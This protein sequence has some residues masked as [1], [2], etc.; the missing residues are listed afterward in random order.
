MTIE[1]SVLGSF[2]AGGEG[3]AEIVAHDPITQ[4]LFVIDGASAEIDVLDVSDPTNPTPVAGVSPI[5]NPAFNTGGV[6]PDSL[7]NSIDVRDGL[8]AVA[9]AANPETDPGTVFFYDTDGNLIDSVTVG[10]L[11]DML[12][13][14]PDGTKILVAN[15]GE[16]DGTDP[17]GS[18]SIIDIS[19]GVDGVTPPPVTQ[20]EFTGFNGREQELRNDGVRIFEGNTAAQDFEPEYIAVSPDGTT[21][22]V[23]L[24]ENNAVAVLDIAS[25]TITDVLPLGVKDYSSGQPVLEQIDLTSALPDLGVTDGGQTIKLG[26]L[27]GLH[28]GGMDGDNMVFFTVPDRGPNAEPTNVDGDPNEERPLALPDYQA[29]I[30]EF[31]VAPDGTV[32]FPDPLFLTRDDDGTSVPITGRP[33][34]VGD[35]EPVDLNGNPLA[36]DPFGGDFEGIVRASDGSFWMVDEYRPAIYHFGADGVLI[37][38]FVPEG[39]GVLGGGSAGDFGTE[40]LPEEYAERR[41]NRGFEAVALDE[42]NGVVYA[43]IQT[44]LAN[45]DR[46][47]SDAPDTIRVLGIDIATGNPVEEYVYQLEKHNN[48]GVGNRNVDKIGDAV[49]AGD[50][51]FF[52]I[53]RDSNTS[54][55]AKKFIF[56]I[57]LTGATNLIDNPPVLPAG[58]TLEQQTADELAALGVQPVAKTKVVNLP[59]IGYLAGDKPE[60]L[61]LLPDGSLAVLNDNDFGLLDQ[62]IPIDGTVPLAPETPPVTLGIISFGDDNGIDPSD[63]DGPAGDPVINF[64]NPP[65][66][67]MFMPDAIA[68][69]EAN[70]A[71]FYVTANEGDDRGEDER[72]GD[73]VNTVDATAPALD[74]TVF[75]D[76]ANLQLD[77]NLGR[78]GVSTVDGD[79]DGDGDYD[80]LFSYGTRSFSIW[81]ETGNLVFDSGDDFEQITAAQVPTFFNS[82]GAPGSFDSRSDNKGPEPEGVVVGEVDGQTY[83][84]IGLERVGGIMVYNVTDPANASFVQ[85]INPAASQPAG[86]AGADDVAP[87]GLKFISAA[88]SPTGQPL[89][90]VG[91]EESGTVTLYGIDSLSGQSPVI[92]EFVLNHTSTDTDEFIEIFAD[93]NTDLSNLSILEIEGDSA[94]GTIDGVFNLGTT[95]ANGFFTTP[96]I[97][98][99]LENGTTTLLLVD[100]FTGSVGDDIDQDNDG[101]IDAGAPWI[102]IVD[103]VAVTDGGSGDLT[104][105]P[106]V[107]D[108]NFD[109][110]GNT[111]GGASRIPDGTDTDTAA[112]FV[113]ND[114]DGEGLPSFPNAQA[115][116]G[117]AINTPGAANEVE[118]TP[119][120]FVE[121]A[122]FEIQGASHDS[123]LAG[124]NVVTEGI[125]TAVD[126][127]GFYMQDP[128]GDGDIATSDGIFVFTGSAPTTAVG[129]E[130]RVTGTVVEFQPFSPPQPA[131]SLTITQ[132]GGAVAVNILS[133]GNPLPAATILGSAGRVVPNEVVEDDAFGSF[134]PETDGIDFFESLEGMRVTIDDPVAI[135]QI[136]TFSSSSTNGEVWTLTDN[137]ANV[138]PADAINDR[139]GI[140]LQPDVN[141]QGDQNPE[142][143]QIQF[144]STLFP[145]ADEPL[146]Q[147]GDQLNDVTGVVNYSFGNYEVLATSD[148]T[149]NV[150]ST[151]T[152]E[153][154]E[155]TGSDN[156]LTVASYNVLNLSPLATDDAQRD[157]IAQQIVNNLGSPDIIAL[158]EIQDADGTNGGTGSTVVDG[159]ATLQ[160]LIDAINA[161]DP[162]LNYQLVNVDPVDDS[163]GGV[164]GGNIRNAYLYNADR[165]G[166]VDFESL[167]EGALT[168]AGVGDP[169]AFNGTRDPLL[170]TFDFNGEQIT[171]INN[172]LS[173]RFGS[174]PVYG[175]TQPFIQAGEAEREAQTKTLNEFVDGL[176]ATDPEANI[177]VLG[178]MNTFE[179][180]DELAEF[181]PG[182]GNEKVLTNLIDSVETDDT[183]SFNFEGNSQALDHVF[184]SDNLVN[185]AELDYVH[186]NVDF[187]RIEPDR[188]VADEGTASDHEPLVARF[189]FSPFTLQLLHAADQEAGIPALDDAPRFSAVLNALADDFDNT[190]FL[191][192][193]D[194]VIP[195][196]FFSASEQVFGAVGRGDILIQNELG[197]QAIAFGNHEFDQGPGVVEGFLEP[198]AD[199]SFV[200][201]AAI[202]ESQEVGNVPDTPAEGS[203][204]A[205]LNGNILFVSGEFSDLTSDLFNVG[206]DDRFG[207]PESAVHVHLGAA[208]VNGGILGN[209]SVIDN[210]DGS[211]RFSGQ[212]ELEDAEAAQ[213]LADGL[214]INLHTQN[215][216]GGELRGQIDLGDQTY[217]GSDFPYLSANLDFSADPNLQDLVVPDGQ[218]PQPNSIAASVVIDVNGESIG[219]VG[220]TT[221]TLGSISSPGDNIGI[222]PIDFDSND[223]ADIAALAAEIQAAVDALPSGVN[224]VILLAHMQQISIEQALASEL[225]GV[226]IIMA[227][228]SNTLLADGTDRLRAGDQ[229]E[230]PYPILETD[231]DGNPV[232]VIN[233]DGNYKYVGRLVVQFDDDGV[234]IPDSIDPNVSGAYATDEQGVADLNAE[235]LVDPEVKGI[236]DLLRDVIV[237]QD[238]NFFGVTTEF[239]NGTRGDVRT[240]ETNLGNLTAD[241]NLAAAKEADAT[242]VISIKNGGGIRDNIGRI[243]V[244]PGEVEPVKLPPAGNELSGKPEGGI[245]QVDIE[246]SLRFNNG[247]TLL[248]VTAEELLALIE[249]G[250]SGTEPGATPGRFPQVSGLSF[251][252]DATQPVGE[253]VVSLAVLNEDGSILDVVAANSDLV[254]DAD[255]TFR[256]VTLGFLA[257]GGDGYPFPDRDRVDLNQPDDAPRTGE[258]DF[259]ED[260]SEQD[261]L[262]EFLAA[263]F[264]ENTPFDQADTDPELDERI[265]NLA[266]RD[267]SVLEGLILGTD[268][269]DLIR[270]TAADEQILAL[271]GADNV[272]AGDG[273]DFVDGGEGA[274]RIRGGDGDDELFGAGG[275]DD[276]R[277]EDGDDFIRGGDGSDRIRG[278]DGADTIT[279]DDGNDDIRAGDGDDEVRGGEGNDR[280]R[281]EDGDDMLFGDDGNDELRGGR[282][283]DILEGGDGDDELRGE[284]GDDELSGGAGNDELRGGSGDDTLNGNEGDDLLRGE[285]G[286]DTY[287]LTP[288]TGVDT[289]RGFDEDDDTLD[290]SAFNLDIGDA[291]LAD[292][293]FDGPTAAQSNGDDDD[294]D[295]GDDDDGDDDDC[296]DD[297]CDDEGDFDLGGLARQDGRDVVIDLDLDAGDQVILLGVRLDDLEDANIII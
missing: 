281:G 55:T 31:H 41:P 94:T 26:G 60:G 78:L 82:N 226:D 287:V 119:P 209:L 183:Y 100:G 83:A 131:Q 173:S 158:Q 96:F 47:A 108:P 21:A 2:D 36:L 128:N 68:S 154:T 1:L 282:H 246:N 270:G 42:D 140:D 54:E 181:L 200:F 217:Q 261:A 30:V 5:T 87:E 104:Y 56:E 92:N 43:F 195:G 254:G 177:V 64:Q 272:R 117:E 124:Q 228:G 184:V 101:F 62:E 234:I 262:A 98:N 134:D 202:E 188:N 6:D 192:S 178:D 203:F 99:D 230:G 266:V 171:L 52:V 53:E 221:P 207:N 115:D 191:S 74:P 150:P 296:D 34:L 211:G 227:G 132:I 274:D 120:G 102:S 218:A 236:T 265:Q 245:S 49:Y 69:F 238:S 143:V 244:P 271:G 198:D 193:G 293:D 297:D 275:A 50:G 116:V 290:L 10:A 112:D 144:D 84:F 148:V 201:G 263:N 259:A 66:F 81:D 38:R 166:L 240:Q 110:N 186:T 151:L 190:L 44:P 176:L 258:A 91:N 75:P 25:A 292:E 3:A 22:F 167:T 67:G 242:T 65:V 212:F 23:T 278:G 106:V 136:R 237:A 219:V 165:V 32:T 93:P 269:A 33:N 35:E 59:S 137:G 187:P 130:V 107:L 71:T 224:K 291:G 243:E 233:T 179:F 199:V 39:T 264:G 126:S 213:A 89:L 232:A 277:G 80:Q 162:S 109:G 28:F 204:S 286:D 4:R 248:T 15:E 268:G 155:L 168:A 284:Q 170:A 159:V 122:I 231:A 105:S 276:I 114:F 103:S 146:I 14:T 215:N 260:G 208:G 255:R 138:A 9:V 20:V 86:T 45:P 256:L 267:D 40:T 11:P 85:Y 125:V 18:V 160:A 250:V 141:N 70:G 142:R 175:N 294:D 8:V 194:A 251:S 118:D 205:A 210:G 235:D 27:S 273:N 257:D 222:A 135:S 76:A 216:Q 90:A 156:E 139:G 295:D 182:V 153:V 174:S 280:I 288:G 285:G 279:G 127:N 189:D 111:V 133:S 197:F 289:I 58:E 123:P 229:A 121:A 13:F 223:P 185:R 196:V 17:N 157:L 163:G 206:G 214:Y 37:D 72:I 129:D 63:R 241:A 46:P 29:R 77:E 73:L 97:N 283:D 88:D 220:A 61:T 24:Q 79:L 48:N 95:D 253:R 145:G 147:V 180:T 252:F 51:K 152:Q 239:L 225:S 161:I 249:H 172:H 169:T 113:R 12:T 149:V 57:N 164:P 19:G 7:I 16:P 247:L